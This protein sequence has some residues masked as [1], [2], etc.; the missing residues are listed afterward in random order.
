MYRVWKFQVEI[1]LMFS[2]AFLIN[3][4]D[5]L[6]NRVTHIAVTQFD[7]IEKNKYLIFYEDRRTEEIRKKLLLNLI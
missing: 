7:V 4:T 2:S 1:F 5:E 3:E 6:W